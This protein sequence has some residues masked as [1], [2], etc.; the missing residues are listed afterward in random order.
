MERYCHCAGAADGYATH[1]RKCGGK[2]RFDRQ[3]HR[4]DG[5]TDRADDWRGIFLILFFGCICPPFLLFAIP[6][7]LIYL[8]IWFVAW[9]KRHLVHHRDPKGTQLVVH[10]F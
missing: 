7:T 4:T 3:G 2:F 8:T 6:Y 10:R 9:I 5:Q 1:C